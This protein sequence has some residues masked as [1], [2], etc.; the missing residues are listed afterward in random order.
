M[1]A[2]SDKKKPDQACNCIKVQAVVSVDERGQMVLP[3]DVRAKIDIQQG[4]KLALSTVECNG[5]IS[6]IVLTKADTLAGS[7]QSALGSVADPEEARK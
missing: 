4:G 2:Q 7:V 6:C 1:A 5:E 3:K